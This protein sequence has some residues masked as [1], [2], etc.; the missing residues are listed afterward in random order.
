[1]NFTQLLRQKTGGPGV[2]IYLK[3]SDGTEFRGA[4]A[5]VGEDFVQIET[6]QRR[7]Y[8]ILIAHILFATLSPKE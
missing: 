7:N 4:V 1:M 8:T 2:G 5:A 3:T 6:E